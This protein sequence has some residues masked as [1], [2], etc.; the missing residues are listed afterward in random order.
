MMQKNYYYYYSLSQLFY[1]YIIIF[2]HMFAFWL[3]LIPTL[4]WLTMNP[5]NLINIYI[6]LDGPINANHGNGIFTMSQL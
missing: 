4:A 6:Y 1:L 5:Q 2:T 3:Y